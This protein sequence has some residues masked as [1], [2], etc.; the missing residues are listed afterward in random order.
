MS[1]LTT[2][3]REEFQPQLSVSLDNSP[4]F[5]SYLEIPTCYYQVQNKTSF[6]VATPGPTCITCDIGYIWRQFSKPSVWVAARKISE[7]ISETIG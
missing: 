2:T 4:N 5:W 3:S 7:A 6:K 1:Y